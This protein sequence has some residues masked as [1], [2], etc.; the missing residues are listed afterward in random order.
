MPATLPANSGYTY[1]FDLTAD[2][3]LASGGTGTFNAPILSY[4]DDFLH[5]PAGQHVPL[6]YYDRTQRQWGPVKDGL[7]ITIGSIS[8]GPANIDIDGHGVADS[9]AAL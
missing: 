4:I 8:R 2:E 3:A 9:P 6:G 5:F 1:C 7:G